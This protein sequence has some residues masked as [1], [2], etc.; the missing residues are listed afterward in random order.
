MFQSIF[1]HR[2]RK[3]TQMNTD[4]GNM[5]IRHSRA[6]R[7]PVACSKRLHISLDSRLRGNDS[8]AD[9]LISVYLCELP[10]AVVTCLV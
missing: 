3:F 4:K 6:G 1:Y 7:S 9:V 5:M 2:P 10:G 8:E